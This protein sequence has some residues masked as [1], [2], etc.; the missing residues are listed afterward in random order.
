MQLEL[1]YAKETN[2]LQ[3]PHRYVPWVTVDGEPLYDVRF[4]HLILMNSIINLYCPDGQI[5]T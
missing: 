5:P 3:P 1:A 4:H 2:A